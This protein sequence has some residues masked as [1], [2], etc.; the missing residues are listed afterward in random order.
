MFEVAPKHFRIV[1]GL[2][3]AYTR[4]HIVCEDLPQETISLP[5]PLQDPQSSWDWGWDLVGSWGAGLGMGP[6][7]VGVALAGGTWDVNVSC[8]GGVR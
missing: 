3:D 5:C 2:D 8:G 6:G 1:Y 4:I 7:S